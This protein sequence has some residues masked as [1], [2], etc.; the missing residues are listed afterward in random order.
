M[1]VWHQNT[2]ALE[3]Q[4][5]VK[6]IGIIQEQHPDRCRLFMQWKQMD[7]PIL[8]DSLNLLDVGVVPLTVLI[9]E[10]GVVKAIGPDEKALAEFVAASPAV[11]PLVPPP[12]AAQNKFDLA[13]RMMLFGTDDGLNQAIEVY[14]QQCRDVPD[15]G[16]AHFRLGVAYR[17][18]FDNA[19][20]R[21]PGDFAQSIDQWEK[22]LAVNPN[23]YIWRRRIQQYGPRLD[24]PYPF[25]DWVSQAQQEIKARG[26][27]PVQLAVE[28][29]GAEVAQP[30]RGKDGD[31]QA[32]APGE[33]KPDPKGQINRDET[34]LFAIESVVV[35]DTNNAR[36]A[37]RIHILLTPSTEAQAKWNDEAGPSVVW[38]D[39]PPGWTVEQHLFSL[40]PPMSAGRATRSIEFEA[41]RSESMEK[42]EGNGRAAS[43]TLH[44]YALYNVCHGAD[45][46]C[47]YLRQ[48]FEI[49]LQSG[50]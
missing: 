6:T 47:T 28:L 21:Q 19:K 25:Y 45:G 13:N 17:Q 38:I 18:R 5:K 31:G 32:P 8:V 44:G 9:D 46:I 37:V 23:Q 36:R 3:E 48:D 15:D 10:A 42:G 11:V 16:R 4:G 12:G 41:R 27:E 24:K 43:A 39:P 7:F 20:L 26:E 2:R 29:S 22:A 34:H 30:Q 35:P 49:P 33:T 40:V 1:P 14:E 50:E